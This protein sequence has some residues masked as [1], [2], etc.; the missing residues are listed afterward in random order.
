M[1]CLDWTLNGT[2]V[3]SV[4]LFE[5]RKNNKKIRKKFKDFYYFIRLKYVQQKK[6]KIKFKLLSQGTAWCSGL[7]YIKI[8]YCL[9]VKY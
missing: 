9:S 1:L 7:Q 4:Q 8:V 2:H 3:H 6:C 5:V